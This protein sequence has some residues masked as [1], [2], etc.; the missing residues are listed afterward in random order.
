MNWMGND[1]GFWNQEAKRE[2]DEREK[3]PDLAQEQS[4]EKER[5]RSHHSQ[6]HHQ[7]FGPL[8]QLCVC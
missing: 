8:H 4:S 6:L 2:R 1:G 3:N 5:L 7:D